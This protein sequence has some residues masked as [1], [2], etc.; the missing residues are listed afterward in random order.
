MRYALAVLALC[1]AAPLF[2]GGCLGSFAS[3][4]ARR[5][6]ARTADHYIREYAEPELEEMYAG[7][8]AAQQQFR[9]D[10]RQTRNNVADTIVRTGNPRQQNRVGVDDRGWLTNEPRY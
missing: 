4:Q 3:N 5:Q 1:L 10:F 8:P 6:A 7:D 9:D 2:L